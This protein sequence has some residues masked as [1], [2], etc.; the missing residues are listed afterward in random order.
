MATPALSNQLSRMPMPRRITRIRSGV[1]LY[2][3]EDMQGHPLAYAQTPRMARLIFAAPGL[4]TA[5]ERLGETTQNL[6]GRMQAGPVEGQQQIM[7]E[8]LQQAL[9]DAN[10]ALVASL[11]VGIDEEGM[12]KAG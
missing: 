7:L 8:T 4:L 1:E 10:T 12:I 3:V 5:M 11:G 9:E 2:M 6:L